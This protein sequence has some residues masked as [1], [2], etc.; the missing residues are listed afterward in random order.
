MKVGDYKVDFVL[1]RI[2]GYH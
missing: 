2:G 1:T